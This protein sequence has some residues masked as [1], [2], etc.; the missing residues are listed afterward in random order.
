MA[1]NPDIEAALAALRAAGYDVQRHGDGWRVFKL[2]RR[3]GGIVSDDELLALA[4]VAAAREKT[5]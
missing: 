5:A 4:R 3:G 1:N 2:L